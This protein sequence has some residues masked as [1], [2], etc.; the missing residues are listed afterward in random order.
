MASSTIPPNYAQ[1][2]LTAARSL[3]QINNQIRSL[4]N[5]AQS[6]INQA[7][8]LASL[9]YNSLQQLQQNVQRT[10]QLLAAGAEHCVQRSERRPDV[11]TALRASV[12]LFDRRSIGV[13]RSRALADDPPPPPPP[14]PPPSAACRTRCAC[15]PAPSRISTA[16][17]PRCPRSSVR[18][19][20]RPAHCKRRGPVINSSR[21]ESQQLSDLVAVISANGRAS[22]ITGAERA[23]AADQGREQRRRFLTPGSGYQP[24]NARMFG[25]GN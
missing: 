13:G 2:V 1:N 3:E 9:P 11:P 17:A 6:L 22:A 23:T 20:A 21:F 18:A 15:R 7:R 10:Q 14:P 8:N 19:R 5:E 4:Q 24:G 12:A 16:T 25:N